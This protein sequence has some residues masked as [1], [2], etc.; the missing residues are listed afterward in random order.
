MTSANVEVGQH[1]GR[2]RAA[3]GEEPPGGEAARGDQHDGED[4]GHDGDD[5]PGIAAAAVLRRLGQHGGVCRTWLPRGWRQSQRRLSGQRRPRC[6]GLCQNPEVD[7]ARRTTAAI[8]HTQAHARWRAA[9]LLGDVRPVRQSSE[10]GDLRR[11]ARAPARPATISQDGEAATEGHQ[12]APSA[13]GHAVATPAGVPPESAPATSAI[14]EEP[15]VDPDLL[16]QLLGSCERWRCRRPGDLR[17]RRDLPPTPRPP[18]IPATA[19]QTPTTMHGVAATAAMTP[20]R[21]G[22][23]EPARG[24][25]SRSSV[26]T[27]AVI[28]GTRAR[29][30]A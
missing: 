14:D 3:G 15:A 16:D 1:L 6:T 12:E 25:G 11:R 30:G 24:S 17:R 8:G 21:R 5:A 26:S 20:G 10:R 9:Q 7:A 13:T 19:N 2:P 4:R 18:T 28:P 27:G 23:G 29:A 22:G